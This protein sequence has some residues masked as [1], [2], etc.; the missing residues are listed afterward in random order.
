VEVEQKR[1]TFVT[2]DEFRKEALGIPGAVESA[3]VGHPDFRIAGKVFASLGAP[4]EDWGMVKL[5]PKEQRLYIEETPGVFRPCSGAWGRRGYTN[6]HLA[7]STK[8][9]VVVALQAAATNVASHAKK[10]KA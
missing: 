2:A 6:V 5:T 9:K 1:R 3:H 8:A 7:S 4:N 10:R